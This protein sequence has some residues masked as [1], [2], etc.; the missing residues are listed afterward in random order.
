M[1]ANVPKHLR[2]SRSCAKHR[3]LTAQAP[4][5]GGQPPGPQEPLQ[6][7]IHTQAT[8][9]RPA[10]PRWSH[11]MTLFVFPS[12]LPPT[13]PSFFSPPSS[14]LTLLILHNMYSWPGAVRTPQ[15]PQQ[16][17]DVSEL[18]KSSEP[19]VLQGKFCIPSV[20]LCASP[21]Q[22]PVP[23]APEKTQACSE[24]RAGMGSWK[25]QAGV[26]HGLV[27]TALPAS[28]RALEGP[29]PTLAWGAVQGLG[30]RGC[31][32]QDGGEGGLGQ[33]LLSP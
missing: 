8:S 7:Y 28:F 24:V 2:H 33:P 16:H 4:Q 23:L 15:F 5:P 19:K 22:A 21:S 27:I 32:N 14:F 17:T 30:S 18:I 26:R 25:H 3:N 1:L 11:I 20:P 6:N 12:S 13:L 9:P 10:L 31:R 29:Q